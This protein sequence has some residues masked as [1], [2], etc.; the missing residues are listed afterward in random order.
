MTLGKVARLLGVSTVRVRELDPLLKPSRNALG[1]R[2]Y[3]PVMVRT[4][5]E[6]RRLRAAKAQRVLAQ[7]GYV[8]APTAAAA[9]GVDAIELDQLPLIRVATGDGRWLYRAD[10]VEALCGALAARG[11]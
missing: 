4:V 2:V 1:H 7:R 8:D 10:T 11:R 5:A 3:D 6:A 9:L